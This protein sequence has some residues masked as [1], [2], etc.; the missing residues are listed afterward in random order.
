MSRQCSRL[1]YSSSTS[2]NI[3]HRSGR[4]L[5][6]SGKSVQSTKHQI[7]DKLKKHH[8][9]VQRNKDMATEK[10]SSLE[11]LP[12]ELLQHIFF[13]ALEPNLPRAS[14]RLRQVLSDETIY[15]ALTLLAYFDDDC[16]SPVEIRHFLPAQYRRLSC[17][18]KVQLQKSICTCHWFTYERLTSC[19]PALARLCIVQAWH[20]EHDEDESFR[21]S[22]T[23]TKP[24]TPFVANTAVR[25]LALLPDLH[26][27]VQ[28]LRHYMARITVE[29][30][31]GSR[32]TTEALD[33]DFFYPRINTWRTTIDNKGELH[34]GLDRSVSTLGTR[35]IP[36]WLLCT[37]TWT[38]ERLALLQLLRQG[39]TFIQDDHVMDI[40]AKA[41]F[42]GM[43]NA[44]ETTNVDALKTLL[45]LHS[46]FFKSGA[47]TFQNMIS[48]QLT[49]PTSHPLPLDLFHLA[50]RQKDTATQLL[51][52]L[53]RAGIDVL[54][55]DDEQ[56]TGWAV[57]E[58]EDGNDLAVWLLKH[59]EATSNYGLTRRGHLFVD[60]ALSWRARGNFPFPST[61]FATE[62]S[63]LPGTPIVPSG[64]D[65]KFCGTDD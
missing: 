8:A 52:L 26:D 2:K 42:Q 15:I 43:R 58:S 23:S 61:S 65:G 18:E 64:L 13:F 35:H 62:L 20:S 24:T 33:G 5:K 57:H 63:Y 1:S 37:S 32:S 16:S 53:L 40:S 12:V 31:S 29:H 19:L 54:P 49:P 22:D 9:K 11:K 60:G 47:W 10:L 51:K 38:A 45:E 59:M 48:V 41:V 39:Y 46:A 17:D 28:L 50:I 25:P 56:V 44:I 7:L 21:K 34:K 4:P 55:H 14:L 30:L 6:A 3:K 27:E 36:N